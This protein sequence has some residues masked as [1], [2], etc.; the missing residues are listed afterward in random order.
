[1]EVRFGRQREGRFET[2]LVESFP[3]VPS[4]IAR[5]MVSTLAL[6]TR[7]SQIAAVY[8]RP[9]TDVAEI[10]G[11]L[12]LFQPDGQEAST[13]ENLLEQPANTGF[14]TSVLFDSDQAPLVMHFTYSGF[15]LLSSQRHGETWRT[16]ILGRQ[17][18]GRP[19]LIL[20]DASNQLHAVCR[21]TRFYV[22]VGLLAY[23]RVPRDALVYHPQRGTGQY[24]EPIPAPHLT[25]PVDIVIDADEQPA[26]L[27]EVPRPGRRELVLYRR[28]EAGWRSTLLLSP[29]DNRTLVS[30]LM[31]GGDDTL[32]FAF[33]ES[34]PD[35]RRLKFASVRG[36][37]LTAED[38]ASFGSHHEGADAWILYPPILRRGRHG[39]PVIVLLGLLKDDGWLK[40]FRRSK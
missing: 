40:T 36:D 39:P 31:L 22:D 4:N 35:A 13:L 24:F 20:L 9:R 7:D 38:V 3:A 12:V 8:R 26:I 15:Y 14:N 6:G 34:D 25:V 18:D 10:L 32:H 27:C 16:E 11:D 5:E 1:V 28:S 30:G 19:G 2:S 37:R 23:T 33:V 17:G 29:M 21:L